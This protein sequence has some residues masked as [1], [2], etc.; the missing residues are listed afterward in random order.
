MFYQ[1]EKCMT[2]L[3]PYLTQGH[4]RTASAAGSSCLSLWLDTMGKPG[5]VSAGISRPAC[6][7]SGEENML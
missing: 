3:I 5:F 2:C 1:R 7:I 6:F 4:L